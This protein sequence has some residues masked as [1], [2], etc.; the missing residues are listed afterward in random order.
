VR[1]SRMDVQLIALTHV[2]RVVVLPCQE[3]AKVEGTAQKMVQCGEWKTWDAFELP[4]DSG[5]PR[6]L[7]ASYKPGSPSDRS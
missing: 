1:I 2:G 5:C 6:K 3:L 7:V 4:N